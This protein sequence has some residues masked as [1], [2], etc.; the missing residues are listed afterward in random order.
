MSKTLK[1]IV[2]PTGVGKTAFAIRE[3]LKVGSPIINA[4]SRQLYRD[5]P[6]GT[7]APTQEEQNLVKHY[8][9]GTLALTDYFSAAEYEAQVLSLL[10][11]LFQD[12]DTVI[13]TGGSM[14]YV[15]AVCNGI[16]DIPTI[17]D[18]TRT[19]MRR[20][21]E[22]EG[23]ETLVKELRLL[24]PEYYERCDLRNY[25]RVIHALEV[26]YMTG[27]TF[28][29]FRTGEKKKRPF[30]IEK[31]GLD[32]PRPILYDR[33]NRRVDAMMAYGL[34][35]EAIRLAPFRGSNALDTIGYKELYSYLDGER[36]LEEAV[37]KIK[38]NSRV[39]A[40][41]QLTWFRRD[42]EMHWIDLESV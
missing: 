8:F 39:Y 37:E 9:V 13:L 19:L 34:L 22:T 26:I 21:Y 29:S 31:I 28:T 42:P 14:M 2:G 40:K 11:T 15:D 24:D 17:D 10:E 36:T 7:A 3:A 16:D 20:R 33:I 38:R 25:K 30:Q 5:L 12:H 1:V 27:R 32:R 35:E 41:K 23:P 6:I 18:E 4:D